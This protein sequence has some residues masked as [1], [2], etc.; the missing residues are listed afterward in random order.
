MVVVE[1]RTELAIPVDQ[2]DFHYITGSGHAP[3]AS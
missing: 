1:E 2:H 3:G